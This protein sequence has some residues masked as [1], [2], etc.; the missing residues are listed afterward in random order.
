MLN[1][2]RRGSRTSSIFRGESPLDQEPCQEQILAG[3]ET[4]EVRVGYPN[5]LWLRDGDQLKLNDQHTVTIGRIAFTTPQE[6]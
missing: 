3:A 2:C 5:I 4:I 6:E 1:S